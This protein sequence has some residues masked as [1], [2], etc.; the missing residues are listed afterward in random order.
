VFLS[1]LAADG[2]SMV[3]VDKVEIEHIIRYAAD[4]GDRRP[5]PATSS[6]KALLAFLPAEQRERTVK[7]VKLARHTER[8]VT[9]ATAL[10][11]TLA[12]IQRTGV[13]VSVDK[14]VCGAA[15]VSAPIFDR[16]GRV[17]GVC[18]VGGPTDRVRPQVRALT[19]EVKRTAAAIS[20]QLGHRASAEHPPSIR[21]GG[22]HE[23]R[24]LAE[25]AHEA[26]PLGRLGGGRPPGAGRSGRAA[27][28]R[29]A[30]RARAPLHRI[31][32]VARP[33]AA[34]ETTSRG[35]LGASRSAP[36]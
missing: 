9:S 15:G 7:A 30:V 25:H 19:A 26:R 11:A 32:D 28:L 24:Y 29:L 16:Q 14:F 18:T 6:G 5:L 2:L 27:R 36:P 22:H 3:Y 21:P 17:V 1:V 10:R 20:A 23:S 4:V 33:H 35:A 31:L 8:T 12:E 13:P 34:A